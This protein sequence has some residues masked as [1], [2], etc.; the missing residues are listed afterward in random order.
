MILRSHAIALVEV[1]SVGDR[2]PLRTR[3]SIVCAIRI[4]NST[5]LHFV[6]LFLFFALFELLIRMDVACSKRSDSGERRELGKESEK[7]R[8]Y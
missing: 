8:G 1:V 5:L 3:Y 6:G 7:K 4:L 2:Y